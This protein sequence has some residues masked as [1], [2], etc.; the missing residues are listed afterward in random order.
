M[1]STGNSAE[2][3]AGEEFRVRR[4]EPD[5]PLGVP[6]KFDPDGNVQPFAGNTIVAHLPPSDKLYTSLLSLH[7]K[8]AASPLAHLFALLPP[9]SW[10]MTVFEGVCDRVRMPGLWPSDLPL[11]TPLEQVTAHFEEK[12][13]A[14]DVVNEDWEQP[15]YRLTVTGFSPLFVGIGVSL[16][17][18]TLEEEA[19]FRSLR[20]RL[21][22]TLLIRAAHHDNYDLHLSLAYFVRYP[23][24]QQKAELL[25]LLTDHLNGGMPWKFE[26]GAPEFCT[27]ENMYR[28]DRLLYLGGQ[29]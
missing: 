12:L 14:F 13:T 28:F 11:N 1:P 8:L 19:R 3:P 23:D 18:G 20:D 6:S 22:K 5:Y 16:R 2:H 4:R 25:Q 27:F 7:A 21:S 10:H 26:L 29:A 24:E 9:P 15:P 17:L